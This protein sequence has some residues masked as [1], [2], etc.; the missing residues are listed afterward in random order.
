[1]NPPGFVTWIL[2]S[3]GGILPTMEFNSHQSDD[4]EAACYHAAAQFARALNQSFFCL[5]PK[6]GVVE[7]FKHDPFEPKDDPK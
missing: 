3:I 1:M 6:D 4:P 7:E 2:I 5:N